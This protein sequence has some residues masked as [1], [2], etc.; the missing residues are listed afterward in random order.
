MAIP[1]ANNR[2]RGV[3]IASILLLLLPA[4]VVAVLGLG[5]HGCKTAKSTETATYCLSIHRVFSGPSIP[6]NAMVLDTP[7]GKTVRVSPTPLLSSAQITGI[8][9]TD[10]AGHPGSL[11]LMLDAVGRF[12]WMQARHQHA[13]ELMAVTVDGW[14]VSIVPLLADG[15]SEDS[16][17]LPGPWPESIAKALCRRAEQNYAAV[18]S[19]Q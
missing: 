6:P 5:S 17:I 14:F 8:A 7:N 18:N 11:R 12:R 10:V 19:N 13:G 15:D 3:R 9:R 4:T 1:K 16:V 2:K